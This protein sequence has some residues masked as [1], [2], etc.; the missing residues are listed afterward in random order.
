VVKAARTRIARMAYAALDYSRHS[1][2]GA[3]NADSAGVDTCLMFHV[4]QRSRYIRRPLWSTHRIRSTGYKKRD[5]TEER[6]QIV[7]TLRTGLATSADLVDA[8]VCVLAGADFVSGCA[9]GPEDRTLAEREGW[10]WTAT[11][12]NDSLSQRHGCRLVATHLFETTQR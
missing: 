7:A 12:L 4:L 2:H 11:T 10:I 9:M 1:S 6:R 8:A 3:W 5:Q